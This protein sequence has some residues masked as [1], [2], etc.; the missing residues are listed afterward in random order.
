MQATIGANATTLPYS[1]VTPAMAVKDG[2]V[3][4]PLA[5]TVEDQKKL[6]GK[7]AQLANTKLG[8]DSLGLLPATV[9]QVCL[10][11]CGQALSAHTQLFL[12]L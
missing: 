2:G 11:P 7:L 6:P 8:G 10:S 5:K 3:L 4:A 9:A 12:S 1:L